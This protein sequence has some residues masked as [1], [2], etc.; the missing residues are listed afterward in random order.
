MNR[1]TEKALTGQMELMRSRLS[2]E[3]FPDAQALF[4][5]HLLFLLFDHLLDHIAADAAVLVRSQIAGQSQ[6]SRVYTILHT[7]ALEIL[8]IKLM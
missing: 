4:T 8:S 2:C 3:G 1:D 5:C 7:D 6:W